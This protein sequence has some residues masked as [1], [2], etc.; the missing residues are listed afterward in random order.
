MDNERQERDN[1]IA[2]PVQEVKQDNNTSYITITISSLEI[3]SI[4]LDW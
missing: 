2:Y 4:P 3:I 1:Y